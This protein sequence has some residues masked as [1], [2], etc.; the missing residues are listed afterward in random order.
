MADQR[1][2]A[3]SIRT[4]L[5]AVF[6]LFLLLVSIL[7]AFSIGE[8]RAVDQISTVIRDRWLQSTRVL[9]DLNNSSSDM[10]AA[11]ANRLLSQSPAQASAVEVQ[12][13]QLDRAVAAAEGA[14]ARL[15]HDAEE[16]A[17]YKRF[18]DGWS[19]YRLRSE[20]VL[21]AARKGDRA[22]GA[23][24]YMTSSSKAYNAASDALGALTA[25]TVERAAAASGQARATYRTARLLIVATIGLAAVGLVVAVNYVT[26]VISGP[27][28]DLAARMRALA[29]NDT[30]REIPGADRRDE[31][32]EM[33][34]AVRIFRTNAIELALSQQGL[35][36][37]ASML[38]ERLEA[39]Q[40][41]TSLQR[42]FVSMASHEFRTPLT[43]IDGHAQRLISMRERIT[44]DDLADRAQRIR[45]A[46]LRLRHVIEQL[47]DTNRF[48]DGAVGLY[49]H[50]EAFDPVAL[51]QEVCQLHREISPEADILQR[52]WDAPR[53]CCGDPRLLHQMTSNLLANAVKYSPA[54]G[55]IEV[56]LRAEGEELVLSIQDRGIGISP[57]DVAAIFERYHR[58]SNTAGVV[59]TG[60]GLFLVKMVV[61]LHGGRIGVESELGRGSTFVVRLPILVREEAAV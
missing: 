23:E 5:S 37:Q 3:H 51:I 9:G 50:P 42:N 16:R 58:G 1:I 30:R 48:I 33:A 60:V 14:Y 34:R 8:L 31:I 11:E 12:V 24:L 20:T 38:E 39:E 18:A 36:Q 35:V 45:R 10:R 4:G 6:A 52:T 15:P 21:A 47:L 57:A 7:G 55:R 43:I 17:L 26:R 44:P 54:G 53:I 27:L 13:R 59:G 28:L 49:Y 56:T 32:G 2:P 46:V 61:D 19:A 29:Q 22:A 41:L 40:K 25:R